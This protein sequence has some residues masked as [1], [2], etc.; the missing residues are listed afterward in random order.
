MRT[1]ANEYPRFVVFGNNYNIQ[2]HL[3]DS[4]NISTNLQQNYLSKDT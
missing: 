3:V 1:H 4:A 2:L